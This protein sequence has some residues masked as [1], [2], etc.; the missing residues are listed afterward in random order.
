MSTRPKRCVKNLFAVIHVP[1]FVIGSC[2]LF[3]I[4]FSQ[5]KFLKIL[6][7]VDQNGLITKNI[8]NLKRFEWNINYCLL[9]GIHHSGGIGVCQRMRRYQLR[10]KCTTTGPILAGYCVRWSYTITCPFS[11]YR[12]IFALYFCPFFRFLKNCTHALTI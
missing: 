9:H 1:C 5:R 10:R 11:K 3:L 7:V 2:N 12:N 4:G 6:V 8:A